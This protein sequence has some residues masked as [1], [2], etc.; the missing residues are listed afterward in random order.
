MSRA[1]LSEEAIE[2]S[3]PEV[4]MYRTANPIIPIERITNRI[5]FLFLKKINES[6][7]ITENE[8]KHMYA[9]ESNPGITYGFPKVHKPNVP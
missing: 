4:F 5:I 2:M 9:T 6:G 8:Y 3:G 7:N 1:H